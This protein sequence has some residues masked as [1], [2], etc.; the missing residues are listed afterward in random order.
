MHSSADQLKGAARAAAGL[1][2]GIKGDTIKTMS[3]ESGAGTLMIEP[4]NAGGCGGVII[5]SFKNH[6]PIILT[7]A[8]VAC[9][10]SHTK[11]IM[12]HIEG[13]IITENNETLN[14]IVAKHIALVEL[15]MTENEGKPDG[16]K[17]KKSAQPQAEAK[18]KALKAL[19][20]VLDAEIIADEALANLAQGQPS[21]EGRTPSTP[22]SLPEGA[23]PV[24]MKL[25][26]QNKALSTKLDRMNQEHTAHF[27]SLETKGDTLIGQGLTIERLIVDEAKKAEVDRQNAEDE[28]LAAEA[29]AIADKQASR[30]ESKALAAMQEK[31]KAAD[32]A[33]MKGLLKGHEERTR[34]AVKSFV[35]DEGKLTR[36]STWTTCSPPPRASS[37]TPST[38]ASRAASSTRRPSRPRLRRPTSPSA[39][40][41]RR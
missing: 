6:L 12:Q 16:D 1:S 4:L 17:S 35:L 38:R 29:K 27:E 2:C 20:V 25:Y 19:K 13:C 40:R 24:E 34:S 14:E 9:S 26:H 10:E 28:K 36:A 39:S 21:P 18:L 31:E 32:F 3:K 7:H 37:T 11:H 33:E 30:K 22:N 15:K 5:E 23:T 8:A 41:A